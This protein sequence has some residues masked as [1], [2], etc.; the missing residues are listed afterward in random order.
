MDDF[1]I[2]CRRVTVAG[3]NFSTADTVALPDCPYSSKKSNLS[4]IICGRR[5]KAFH[6]NYAM[7]MNIR[8]HAKCYIQ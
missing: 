2:C 1:N 6:N 5:I 4:L 8:I 3:K 7:V